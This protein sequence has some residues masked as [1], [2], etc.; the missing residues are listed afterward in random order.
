MNDHNTSGL[1]KHLKNAHPR[2]FQDIKKKK[3]SQKRKADEANEEL[4]LIHNKDSEDEEK[5]E[6]S[7]V[8]LP[9]TVKKYRFSAKSINIKLEK[10]GI[11]I[12]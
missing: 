10:P 11:S 5:R 7:H 9:L 4:E 8:I 6:I 1:R 3:A 2:D 12:R